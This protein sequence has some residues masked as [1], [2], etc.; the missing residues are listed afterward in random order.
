[1]RPTSPNRHRLVTAYLLGVASLLAVEL[2]VAGALV[3]PPLPTAEV[4]AGSARPAAG[5]TTVAAD[6][7][8]TGADDDAKEPGAA[9]TSPAAEP[10]EPGD[11]APDQAAAPASPAAPA[12]A[13]GQQPGTIR[14]PDGGTA[15]LVREQVVGPNAVL[16]IPE[17]LDEASWWG[18]GLGAPGGASLFAGHVN[19][20]GQVGPFA[21]LWNAQVHER[22]TVSDEDG[23]TWT[24]RI[25]QVITLGKNELPRRADE[26]FSQYG[27]HRIVLVTC[28]GRW[29]GG[30]TGYAENRVVIAEPA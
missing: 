14:L 17:N 5:V 24:Y 3:L 8:G 16:P 10:A 20:R 25:T 29:I 15:R 23:K 30:S 6:G 21:E 26:L 11:A 27:K 18:V 9:T 1:M 28:G 2:A 7:A 4:V 13:A 12:V 19:W 22:V